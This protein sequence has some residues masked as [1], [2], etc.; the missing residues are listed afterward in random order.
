MPDR[1]HPAVDDM[2]PPGM[3][4][5]IDRRE[6]EPERPPLRARHDAVLGACD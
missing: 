1:V 3:D 6:T 2:Q 4:A 5:V